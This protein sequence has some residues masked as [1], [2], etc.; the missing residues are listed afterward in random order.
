MAA[1]LPLTR[2]SPCAVGACDGAQDGG[3]GLGGGADRLALLPRHARLDGRAGEVGRGLGDVQE[4]E[5]VGEAQ[6]GGRAARGGV[7]EQSQG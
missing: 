4:V 6:L 7:Q 1:R 2:P 5:E 3:D